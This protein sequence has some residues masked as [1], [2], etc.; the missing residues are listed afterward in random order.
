MEDKFISQEEIE[1]EEIEIIYEIQKLI[2]SKQHRIDYNYI[3]FYIDE[4]II[5]LRDEKINK[6]LEN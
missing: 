1:K 5:I 6:I 2:N 4:R 3:K